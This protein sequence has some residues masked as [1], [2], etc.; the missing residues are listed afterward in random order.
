MP[1]LVDP[2]KAVLENGDFETGFQE[3]FSRVADTIF[4]CD[5]YH[6]NHLCT[7]KLQHLRQALAG[8]VAAFESGILLNRRIAS[9]IESKLF[10]NERLQVVVDLA[11]TRSGH[12]VR[13]PGASL[14]NERAMVCGMVVTDKK[15]GYSAFVAF[16]KGLCGCYG[17]Q[18]MPAGKGSAGKKIVKFINDND[19]FFHSLVFKNCNNSPYFATFTAA[20]EPEAL[21]GGGLDAHGADGHAEDG[22]QHGAHCID[23]RA[24][25]RGLQGYGDVGVADLP[26]LCGEHFHHSGEE[27]LA[28]GTLPFGRVVREVEADVAKRSGPE[29][30]ITQ[31]VDGHISVRVGHEAFVRGDLNAA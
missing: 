22:R 31:R 12:A 14:L 4:G 20:Y 21:G 10:G 1:F 26:A 16:K 8:G 17:F 24:E 9:F 27:P 2:A 3:V 19:C 25:F 23:M 6:V 28:I 18:G 29:Q 13:G 11:A 7:K 30:G 15:N 5:T